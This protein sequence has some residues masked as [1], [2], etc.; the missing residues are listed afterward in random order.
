M[1]RTETSATYGGPRDRTRR[2]ASSTFA[3]GMA[4]GFTEASQ[5]FTDQ[6]AD[7]ATCTDLVGGVF[8]G[9][10]RAN[11]RFL[12]E[13]ATVSRRLTDGL[14][15]VDP[16]VGSPSTID[17]ERLADLV[18][19]RIAAAKPN[20]T[21]SDTKLSGLSAA[22][23]SDIDYERLADMVVARMTATASRE[24]SPAPESGARSASVGLESSPE[25]RF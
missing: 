2:D 6:V 17:Y 15:Y 14:A 12:E 20:S 1:D 21:A 4:D 7:T 11:G 9:F 13:M 3:R 8:A 16:E 19:T 10:L 25:E 23:A 5:A 22:A 18:A 24:A